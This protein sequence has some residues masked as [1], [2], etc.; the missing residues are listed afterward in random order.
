MST[1]AEKTKEA[2]LTVNIPM[3]IPL[4]RISDLL[5]NAFEGGS[6]YWYE[7]TERHAPERFDF[8]TEDALHASLH[9][10]CGPECQERK[11]LKTFPHLDYPLNEG[12]HLLVKATDDEGY[13][14]INGQT[15]WALDLGAVRQGLELLA[16]AQSA[17]FADFLSENDDAT[18][19]DVFLQ[20]CL[21]GEVVF[22]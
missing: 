15:E 10:N 16:T 5:C 14:E 8:R 1:P 22:G 18:T 4:A 12:G 20:L 17:H 19:G 2:T 7:I 21:F 3:T 11:G 9:G 6:N 13:T